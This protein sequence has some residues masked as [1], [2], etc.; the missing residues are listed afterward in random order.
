MFL[1]YL[2]LLWL[3]SSLQGSGKCPVFPGEVGVPS[4]GHLGLRAPPSRGKC[5]GQWCS[6]L[7]ES[8][9][10]ILQLDAAGRAVLS[11][12]LL[13]SAAMGWDGM[14]WERPSH[15]CMALFSSH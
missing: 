6:K 4:P 11:K 2:E 10:C 14:G 8:Q 9:H 7:V 3:L 5:G 13:G 12:P 15:A 1:F